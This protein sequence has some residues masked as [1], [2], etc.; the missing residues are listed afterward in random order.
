M[1]FHPIPIPRP[2]QIAQF[3]ALGFL[4]LRD[5][6]DP[7]FVRQLAAE[8]DRLVRDAAGAAYLTPSGTGG[9]EG[10]YIP[11]TGRTAPTSFQLAVALG[12]VVEALLG[13][14]AI[15]SEAQH[16]VLFDMAGWHTDT[17]H[18]IASLKVVA[19]MDAL[20]AGNGALRVLPAS[21]ALTRGHLEAYLH[22]DA[23]R[24]PAQ[25]RTAVA[26]VPSYAIS[27]QPGDLI[28]FDEHLFHASAHGHNRRQ[29]AASYV[30]DPTEPGEEA[31]VRRYL[32]SQFVADRLDY[33]PRPYPHYDDVFRASAPRRWVEQLEHLGG[34]EA[35]AAEERRALFARAELV[36]GE[37]ASR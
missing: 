15:L 20:H 9:I 28:V 1:T 36:S 6:L 8:A 19:Y 27:S 24:D 31:A 29:W 10:H 18:D 11:A 13:R 26:E 3:R 21:H 7:P 33:D 25:V 30:I 37:E 22:G 32:A 35:A 12:P 2:A 5:A 16:V 34:F 23:F 17:G 4:V 14:A